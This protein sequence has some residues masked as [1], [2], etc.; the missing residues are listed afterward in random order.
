MLQISLSSQTPTSHPGGDLLPPPLPRRHQLPDTEQD[1]DE[2]SQGHDTLRIDGHALLL[3]RKPNILPDRRE[4][5]S[6]AL[7][8]VAA[9]Q[10]NIPQILTNGHR[11]V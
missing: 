6:V 10:V 11:S 3:R 9:P 1:R 2:P 7:H 5:L 8:P 4:V